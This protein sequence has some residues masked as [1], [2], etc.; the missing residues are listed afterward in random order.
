[1]A[2]ALFA[3]TQ[4]VFAR[5]YGKS[6]Y[7]AYLSALAVMDVMCRGGTGGADKAMLRYVAASRAAGDDAGVR[8]AIG[9]GL[10]LNIAVAGA[11]ALALALG[12]PRIARSLGESSLAPALRILAP[13]PL[14]TGAVWILIQAT[15]AARITKANFF[16]RGVAEPFLLLVAGVIA[17]LLGG[18]LIGLVTAQVASSF[19]AL[20]LAVVVV[21]RALR[22]HEMARVL[23]APRV[24]GFVRFSLPIAI[25]EMLNAVVQRADILI[26]A[27]LKGAEAAALYGAADL[28]TRAIASIR[29][30]F[31]SIVAGVLSETLHLGELQR[32]EYNLRLAIRWVVSAAAPIAVT[33]VV[34]RQDLLGILFGS[35]YVA[36]A[37][38]LVALTLN[39]FVNAS[40]G[41][42]GWLLMVAGRSR[43]SMLNNL[44]AAAFNV[45]AAYLLTIRFGIVGTG[46]AALGTALIFQAAILIEVALLTKV[47]PLSAGLLKPLVA[48]AVMIIVQS[49]LRACIGSVWARLLTVVGAGAAVYAVVLLALGLPEEERLIMKRG[50]DALRARLST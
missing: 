49:A 8:S 13:L 1:M 23:S 25:S 37:G 48:A 21:R 44:I 43:L 30:A 26:L 9:A 6:V 12:A 36:G 20:V 17:W 32:L 24:Y 40:L 4:V 15:L 31:D 38:V 10:R 18:G 3:S 45:P 5:L 39:H 27:T 2:Q 14:L 16:V 7:G 33:V 11:F 22:P 28:L 19:I 46:Y 29:Y 42:S 34:L 35:S 50:L 41:L 47:Y